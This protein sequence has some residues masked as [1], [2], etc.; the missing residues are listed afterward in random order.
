MEKKIKV[1]SDFSGVGAFD[2]A[3]MLSGIGYETEFSCDMDKYARQT[4][5]ANYGEPKYYPE[6]VY[7]REIP[8]EP[9]DIYMTSPPCQAFSMAGN[10][11]GTEDESGRGILFYNSYEFIKEN[12]P[13][14]F[15]FE[16][17]K[18]LLSHDR[19]SKDSSQVG[20][21]FQ[22]WLNYLGGKSVNGNPIIFPIE[23]AVHYHIYYR[24][25]NTKN[26]G[27]PQNRE[28]VF[29]VGIRD[30]ADNTFSWPQEVP[31]TTKLKDV[32]EDSPGDNYFLKEE[33]VNRLVEYDERNKAKGN[34]FGAKFHDPE[35]DNM[36]ALKFGGGGA[37][38]LVKIKTNNSKGYD[39]MKEGDSLN[40]SVLASTTRRGRVGKGIAQTLDTG[41]EQGVIESGTWRTH[42]DGEGFRKIADGT[43]PTI[44]ARAREDGS[45]QPVIR[46]E[47]RIRRLT[48]RECF[49][50]QGFPDTFKIPVSDTQAYKQ[51]GNS[52]TREVL[53]AIISKLNLK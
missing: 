36:S 46:A 20:K 26:F 37:D 3:L 34:G 6:N 22:T 17:V 16:N 9:L 18:G 47:S 21:T 2:Q 24:V 5:I 43:A 13:R 40:F 15:I 39:E 44:P 52:I 27:I 45:G 53:S 31:L 25:L 23:E 51:A 8:S 19:D 33:V 42:K 48:P 32:L 7:D 50:L 1:G 12:N 14:F 28:R 30:D 29:I 49:R 11:K 41:C 10:R 38:D 4:Y 35:K